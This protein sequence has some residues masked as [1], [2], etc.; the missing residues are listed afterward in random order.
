[1]REKPW[2][3][4]L[5]SWLYTVVQFTFSH[6][7]SNGFFVIF[8]SNSFIFTCKIIS[9]SNTIMMPTEYSQA[10]IYGLSCGVSCISVEVISKY[11]YSVFHCKQQTPFDFSKKAFMSSMPLIYLL[12]W[13]LKTWLVGMI[14][15]TTF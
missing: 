8:T 11:V 2:R 14:L 13:R 9:L 12:V 6:F 10:A 15:V 1:M 7:C 3:W 5:W 4:Y